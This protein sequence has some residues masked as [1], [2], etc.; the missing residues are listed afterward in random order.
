M[1]FFD[2][3]FGGFFDLNGD[4]KTTWDEEWIAYKILEDIEKGSE[5]ST[6]SHHSPL[7]NGDT[8]E[9]DFDLSTDL[10]ESHSWRSF[11][12]DGTE[13][14][15]D[16]ADYETEE[17]YVIALKR[18]KYAW[19]EFCEDGSEFDVTPDEYES[20]DE[21]NDALEEARNAWRENCTNEN[22]LGVFPDDYE[23]ED[24]YNEARAAAIEKNSSDSLPTL[25]V[26]IKLTFS[27]ECPALD[28]LDSIKES[29]FPN[30]RQYEAAYTLANKFLIY[31]DKEH[32][33]IEKEICHFILE[34]SSSVI[35][36][37]Y[38]TVSNGFL[39]A[40]AVK[41]HFSLPVE[42]PDEDAEKNTYFSDMIKKIARKDIAL[43]LKIWDWCVE[44]FMPHA[45]F[46]WWADKTL[47]CATI[48]DLYEFPKK[49]KPAFVRYLGEH[50]MFCHSLFRNA[51]ELAN[52]T[53]EFVYIALQS[54]STDVS[55][56]IFEDALTKADKDT[57][58][59]I[60]LISGVISWCNNGDELES[61]ERFQLDLF[62]LVIQYAGD[63]IDEEICDW[64]NEM[65][66]Y[67]RETERDNEKYAFSRCNAWRKTA[68]DGQ[69]FGLN[70]CDYDSEQEYLD[71]L[72]EEKYGWRRCYDKDDCFGLN[73][74]D[75]ETQLEFDVALKKQRNMT[76]ASDIDQRHK[77]RSE[78]NAEQSITPSVETDESILG[79]KN[80][81][82]YCGVVFHQNNQV[83][84]YRTDD[85][86]M[87]IGDAVIVPVGTEMKETEAKVVSVGQYTRMTVPFP[88]EKTRFIIKK[89]V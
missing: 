21:Y 57:D 41:D 50:P 46:E 64:K 5:K 3:I 80:V 33:K 26:P 28:E 17:E 55:M 88:V 68:P 81:Y 36:A 40:Q 47:T 43:S 32:E 18:A 8:F 77:T 54:D 51:P 2:D 1:G 76:K 30:K 71:D 53:S 70:V 52:D 82:I 75:Y 67:I 63:E 73:P 66:E 14:N 58:I 19:R 12:E 78:K 22:D 15:I 89:S 61:T 74:S 29:D 37:K 11:C 35:A 34:S 16:P 84:H 56:L 48:D 65:A 25:S 20:E 27:V 13:L 45:R 79:D 39:Y 42:F 69:K 6:S 60:R 10:D 83:Y 4:G 9:D 38:L 24:E 87:K 23:T 72:N 59:L 85:I 44:Q 86:T 62:P 31:S 49:F 7:L